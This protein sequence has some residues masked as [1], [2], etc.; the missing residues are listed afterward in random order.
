MEFKTIPVPCSPVSIYGSIPMVRYTGAIDMN[1]LHKA[2]AHVYSPPVD[3]EQGSFQGLA[4]RLH[5]ANGA[6][7]ARGTPGNNL[8]Q[9]AQDFPSLPTPLC[10]SKPQQ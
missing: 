8:S 7:A 6:L 2:V 1:N 5:G 3:S 10:P 9:F 4:V